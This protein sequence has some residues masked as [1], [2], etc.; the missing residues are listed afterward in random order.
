[1]RPAHLVAVPVNEHKL[2]TADRSGAGKEPG[3]WRRGASPL[4]PDELTRLAADRGEGRVSLFLPSRRGGSVPDDRVRFTTLVLRVQDAL[5]A[6]GVSSKRVDTILGGVWDLIDDLW[7]WETAGQG[8]A[9]FAS[10]E[11]ARCLRVSTP[12][13]EFAAIGDRF[14]VGPLL[15]M[16]STNAPFLVLVLTSDET[17][18]FRG[19]RF[20]VDEITSGSL[21]FDCRTLLHQHFG[22]VDA[23]VRE[24]AGKEKMP[25]V[26]LGTRHL[27]D[28]YRDVN[29]FPGLLLPTITGDL[30]DLP[31]GTIHRRAWNVVEPELQ[32]HEYA[33]ADE[34]DAQRGTGR[35]VT[36]PAEVAAAA[37]EGRIDTL[38]VSIEA[39]RWGHHADEPLI[40][41][42]GDT[43]T[44]SELLDE[45]A[46]AVLRYSGS[47][48]SLP[49]HR[50]PEDAPMAALLRR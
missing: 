47:V 31:P 34:Y 4:H 46:V 16:L 6:D 41:R 18:L 7:M 5:R 37:R 43:A 42:L 15:P 38:F 36:E 24:A 48:I 32:A 44:A 13:P 33:A 3:S 2:T 17:R 35:T 22:Q 27:Q 29:T 49:S 21:S 19:T 50:M 14:S 8:L 45:A 25:L 30:A 20:V 28:L 9:V 12:L 10:P 40:V 11:S 23:A 26:V 39:T 1:M